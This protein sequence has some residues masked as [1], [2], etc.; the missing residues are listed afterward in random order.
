MKIVHING[1]LGNQLFQYFFGKFVVGKID[2]VAFLTNDIKNYNSH[3]GLEIQKIINEKIILQHA[4]NNIFE[5]TNSKRILSKLVGINRSWFRNYFENSDS[6]ISE[7][8]LRSNKSFHGYWQNIKYY[9]IFR[10]DILKKISFTLNDQNSRKIDQIISTRNSVSVHIRR[11]DYLNSKAHFNLDSKYYFAAIEHVKN[12]YEN[13]TF[14]IF[15]DDIQWSSIFLKEYTSEC[16]FVDINDGKNSHLDMKLM[17]ECK[18]NIIANSTFSWWSSFLNTSKERLI[19]VPSKW[20]KNKNNY[21]YSEEM[22]II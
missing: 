15:S 17:S 16:I 1:G 2:Q 22:F 7:S 14:F 3:Q 5:L 13:P 11:G 4:P 18:I 10:D 9:N 19:I 8:E 21:L 6:M 20:Y 12:E